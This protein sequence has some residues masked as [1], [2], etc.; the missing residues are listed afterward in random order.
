MLSV[1][2]C[3]CYGQTGRIED[4]SVDEVVTAQ[5]GRGT[6]ADFEVYRGFGEPS[7]NTIRRTNQRVE[8]AASLHPFALVEQQY[9]RNQQ[10]L[11][12][13]IASNQF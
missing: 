3:T 13:K 10:R 6:T 11:A 1:L 4:N 5:I 7:E 2:Q 8:H 9:F 12:T